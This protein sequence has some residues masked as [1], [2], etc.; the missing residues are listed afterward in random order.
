M[1]KRKLA[2]LK[3]LRAKL[4]QVFSLYIR[5]R[6]ADENG[7]GRCISCFQWRPL[8]CGHFQKRQH[9]ALRWHPLAAAGQCVRCNHYL[10][11]NEGA[12]ALALVKKYGED[13]V[14]ELMRIKHTTVKF[15]R[16]DLSAMIERFSK[17]PQ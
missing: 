15:T 14:Q 6:D 2:S 11:G 4:D 9:L 1:S 13:V 3:S 5:K 8:Q 16:D 7:M 10:G 12:F 17:P